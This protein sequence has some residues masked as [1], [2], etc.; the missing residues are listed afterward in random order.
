MAV[1]VKESETLSQIKLTKPKLIVRH[2]CTP[3]GNVEKLCNYP[4]QLLYPDELVRK[5]L[6]GQE[7]KIVKDKVN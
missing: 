5:E 7:T 3:W 2:R 6:C 1:F 4:A